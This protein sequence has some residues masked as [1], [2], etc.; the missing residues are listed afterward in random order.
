MASLDDS[1]QERADG[2][3][4]AD[5]AARAHPA[6]RPVW[7]LGA[8]DVRI[9]CSPPTGRSSPPTATRP[10]PGRTIELG[11]RRARG[12]PGRRRATPCRTVHDRRTA[13]T[14]WAPCPGNDDGHRAGPGP[15]AGAD[16]R[17]P[18]A[19]SAFVLFALRAASA[20][21]PPALAGW[22]VARNGLRPVRRLTDAAEEIAR[23]EEL[24]PITVEGNDEIARLATSF[25]AMLA[26]L[27][28]SRDRQRQLVAD[29][30]HELRTPLT[31]LRTNLDL[32]AQADQR[33]GLS[34]R[35]AHRAD[36]RRPV[37]DRR[38]HHPHRRPHRARPR[39]A[40]RRAQL[41]PVDLADV[42]ARAVRPGPPPR[43]R[44]HLRRRRSR[45]RWVTGE[46][47]SLERAITNLLDNAA[48]WSPPDG[49]VTVAPARR[50]P[51]RRRPGPRH[52]RGG[53]A[54]RLRAVLPLDRVAH[55]ARLR[56]RACRSCAASP[57]GTAALVRAGARPGGRRRV[58]VPPPARPAARPRVHAAPG[59]D[60]AEVTEGSQ[61]PLRSDSASVDTLET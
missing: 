34:P 56:A 11:R 32:L 47:A 13:P 52:R 57:S 39:R 60:G 20:W 18:S 30:G 41:E 40:D 22:A 2:C 55:H 33:G 7:V 24:D 58:L 15:V 3:L 46:P 27:S 26:A 5:G 37:P 35:A 49:T 38:A 16:R 45:R 36:G 21:S 53:P 61:R 14:G 19:S 54:P 6:Q 1:L 59:R 17:T 8:A 51:L 31:S 48:K 10:G 12:G 23:T 44:R 25:N 50:H 43:P 4:G 28:A 42:V 29:A 9:A